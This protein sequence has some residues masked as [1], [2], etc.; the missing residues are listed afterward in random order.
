MDFKIHPC[1]NAKARH[2]YARVHLPVAPR[3]NIQCNF[4][5]RK[6]DCVNESR[7]GVTSQILLPHQALTYLNTVISKINNVAVVGI[8]GPGDP[9]ANPE[10]TLETLHLVRKNYP[11]MLLCVASNGL[12]V[13]PYIQ[14]LPKLNLS[15]ITITINTIDPALVPKIYSWMRYEKR[16]RKSEEAALYFIETQQEVIRRLKQ[17]G[18]V[19]KVNTIIIPGINDHHIVGLAK[20]MAH[21]GVDI[22]N[23]IPFYRNKDTVFENIEEPSLQMIS[24]I[25]NQA[26]QYIPQMSHCQRC[27]ADAAGLL[28]ESMAPET[29]ECLKA[30]TRGKTTEAEWQAES[31]LNRPCVAVASL[32]GLLI[33]QHLGEAEELH[34]YEKSQTGFSFLE[35]RKTPPPGGGLKRWQQLADIL[36]DC[37]L[38]LVSG[39]G[40]NPKKILAEK[41]I[42]LVLAEGM[43]S[44]VLSHLAEKGHLDPLSKKISMRCSQSCNGTGSGCG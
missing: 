28:E 20:T 4:C 3:C 41:K 24:D 9:F 18:I 12:N 42:N 43:I 16:L 8:A 40:E 1:F 34:I 17:I 29:L 11:G 31:E 37:Q 26:K 13:L 15:H 44:E 6:Y 5:N 32:E 30:A 23:C 2:Q 14:E 25:R 22:L 35:K 33:N 19:V 27:R 21:L 38:V 36:S 10:E 7:P 39:A